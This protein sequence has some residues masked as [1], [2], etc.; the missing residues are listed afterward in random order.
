MLWPY[1]KSTYKNTEHI[2]QGSNTSGYLNEP[3]IVLNQ[4]HD[5]VLVALRAFPHMEGRYWCPRSQKSLIEIYQRNY[6]GWC[7]EFRPLQYISQSVCD[8][9]IKSLQPPVGKCLPASLDLTFKL[10]R[11][12]LGLRYNSAA[13]TST[14]TYRGQIEQAGIFSTGTNSFCWPSFKTAVLENSCFRSVQ[15]SR[16]KYIGLLFHGRNRGNAVPRLEQNLQLPMVWTK[17]LTARLRYAWF[18]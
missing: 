13:N 11:V 17:E 8:V 1:L 2:K 10:S 6:T 15:S 14:L 7:A 12:K 3:C 16:K 5:A 18:W 4:L 9:P